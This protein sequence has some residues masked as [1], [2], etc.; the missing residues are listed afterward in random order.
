MK[1]LILGFLLALLPLSLHAKSN[2]PPI[3]CWAQTQNAEKKVSFELVPMMM[4]NHEEE[5]A[6]KLISVKYY[7]PGAD[8]GV[9]TLTIGE[10]RAT[11]ELFP[12]K[13]GKSQDVS[14]WLEFAGIQLSCMGTF[15]DVR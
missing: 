2:R 7:G 11:S 9:L 8:S 5:F 13:K 4:A 1:K 15:G 3:K 10:A 14:H 12:Y 6:G